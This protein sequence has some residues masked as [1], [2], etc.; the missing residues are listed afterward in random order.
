MKNTFCTIY[1]VRHGQSVANVKNLY[2]LDTRLTDKGI[3]Q[4]KQISQE[5]KKLRFD[6]I[7]SSDFIRAKHTAEIIAKEHN[8]LV[9]TKKALREKFMGVLEGKSV[10]KVK[11]ELKDLYEMRKSVPYNTWK[12]VRQ[13][14][15]VE[16]D[17]E[18]V[19]R[20]I[21]CLREIAIA[22]SKKVVLIASHVSL[23]KTLLIHFGLG[24]HKEMDG[25]AFENT[26]YIKLRCDGV[27]FFVKEVKGLKKS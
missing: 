14:K 12:T 1:I 6:A 24:N 8:L 22:N 18:M 20:F 9:E 7:Y 15:D 23:M 17:E 13:A 21:T 27:D 25:Q 19:S 3:E 26:G 2:G 4:A 11:E 5:F 16:T 10:K